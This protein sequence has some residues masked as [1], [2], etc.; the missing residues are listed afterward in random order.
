MLLTPH[1]LTGVAIII[2]VQNPIL[3]LIF[4]LLSHYFLDLFPQTEYTIKTIRTG[5]WSRSLPDFLKIFLDILF[6][7][8]VVFFMTGLSPLILAAAAMALFPDIL[9]LLHCIFPTNRLLKKHMKIHIAINAV[10][11]NKKIPGVLGIVSQ[12]IIIIIAIYFLR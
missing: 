2:L 9:T 1:I 8:T 5:Q 10:C 4:I 3:G 6:G 7:L 12:V 11:E